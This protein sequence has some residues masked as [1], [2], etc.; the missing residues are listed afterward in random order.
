MS[1]V[2]VYYCWSCDAHRRVAPDARGSAA[3]PRCG[4]SFGDDAPLASP[5]VAAVGA[6]G[7]VKSTRL[8]G[9]PVRPRLAASR[10]W[11]VPATE[12]AS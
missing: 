1:Q 3:C 5:P 10:R 4:Q 2:I 6:G 8:D 12:A 11:L 9:L 7:G